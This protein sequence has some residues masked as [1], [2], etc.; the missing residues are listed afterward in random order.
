MALEVCTECTCRFAVGLLRCPQC[1]APAPTFAD[2][3]KEDDSMP[4][5]TV[6]GGPSNADAQPGE[7]GYIEG[8]EQPSAG[9]NSSTS[10]GKP[11]PSSSETPTSSDPQPPAPETANPSNPAPP[12]SPE[13]GTADS[14]DGSTPATGSARSRRQGSSTGSR[15]GQG[16][17]ADSRKT[18]KS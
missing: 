10:A 4:R 16:R 15:K 8:S 3:M 18:D 13:P 17:T 11:E 14:T 1:E 2:R 9:T 5:I 7:P 12:A 6:A